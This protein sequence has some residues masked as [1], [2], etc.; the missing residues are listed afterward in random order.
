MNVWL[1]RIQRQFTERNFLLATSY[2]HFH[3]LF[4]CKLDTQ[5]YYLGFEGEARCLRSTVFTEERSMLC[6]N[7][8]SK[9]FQFAHPEIMASNHTK[10]TVFV[11]LG[12]VFAS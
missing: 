7:Q 9:V 5:K 2:W 10:I 12:Q 3:V 1:G 8:L 11:N 4:V 6:K